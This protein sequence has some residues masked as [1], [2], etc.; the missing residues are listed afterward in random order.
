MPERLLDRGL[1]LGS[2]T[3]APGG[4]SLLAQALEHLGQSGLVHGENT[5]FTDTLEQPTHRWI[6]HL[7]PVR[8]SCDVDVAEADLLGWDFEAGASVGAF[9]LLDEA[10]AVE[11]K[12]A[13]SN[14]DS[15]FVEGFCNLC[16]GVHGTWF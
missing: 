1:F 9:A 16:R 2:S 13:T 5:F 8:F 12:E 14:H 6:V 4:R 7:K 10:F 3:V 11:K 15:A